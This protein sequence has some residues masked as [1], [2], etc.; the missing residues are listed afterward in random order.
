[1]FVYLET[2]VVYPR[3]SEN[4][5]ESWH[6]KS[7]CSFPHVTISTMPLQI[8]RQLR[9]SQ[10][11]YFLV[12]LCFFSFYSTNWHTEEP[13]GVVDKDWTWILWVW[14][15]NTSSEIENWRLLWKPRPGLGKIIQSFSFTVEMPL[16][17][18]H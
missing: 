16:Q 5:Q 2:W 6:I 18:Y 8:S 12:L 13:Y 4:K 3:L 17:N 7:P 15:R 9:I 1:M 10:C 11:T 14:E